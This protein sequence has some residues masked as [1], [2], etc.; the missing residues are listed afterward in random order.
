MSV[1]LGLLR[2]L[3]AI[4]VLRALALL[5]LRSLALVVLW[6]ILC[7]LWAFHRVQRILNALFDF[8]GR[9]LRWNHGHLGQLCGLL[10]DLH[11]CLPLLFPHGLALLAAL[12]LSL[13]RRL[14]LLLGRSLLFGLASGFFSFLSLFFLLHIIELVEFGC[15]LLLQLRV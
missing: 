3:L 6:R 13:F 7:V 8:V 4:F 14:L 11:D 10:K 9:G 2:G 12:L 1:G 5:V 15:H